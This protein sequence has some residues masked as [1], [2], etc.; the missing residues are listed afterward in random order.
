MRKG[1]KQTVSKFLSAGLAVAL[2][3]AATGCA[4][5]TT[6]STAIQT[7]SSAQSTVESSDK[8]TGD[9]SSVTYFMPDASAT[10]LQTL[11]WFNDYLREK[12]GIEIKPVTGDLQAVQAMMSSGEL[13]D[14]PGVGLDEIET[15]VKGNMLLNLDEYKDQ[16]SSL[17]TSDIYSS[18]VD[19]CRDAFGEGKA[20]Y[21]IQRQVGPRNTI[22]LDPQLR[23]DIYQKV[24]A[25]KIGTL[26]DYLTVLKSMQ[27]AYPTTEDG[28]KVYGLVLYGDW[29]ILTMKVAT[30]TS[31]FYGKD[32]EYLSLLHQVSADGNGEAISIL[33][34][35]SDYKRTLK[36]YYQANQMG[37]LDP[38]S[39][40]QTWDTVLD[41]YNNGRILFANWAWAGSGYN[42]SEHVNADNPTGYASV[43][44]DDFTIP[45]ESDSITGASDRLLNVS[46][47]CQNKDAVMRFLNWYLSYEGQEF[48]CNGPQGGLWDEDESGKR[49]ITDAGWNII[50]NGLE[51]PQGG[52]VSA[53]NL[54]LSDRPMW[55]EVVNPE[56]K[57][58]IDY[59]YWEDSLTHGRSKLQQ[60]WSSKHDGALDMI[61]AA[62]N[63]GGKQ[64]IKTTQAVHMISPLPDD[65]QTIQNQIGDQVKTISW[66]M[67]YAKDD[68]E[69]EQLWKE[70]QN[71]AKTL[72]IDQLTT[73]M[74]TEL[75][76]A[77]EKL[78][79][80][81]K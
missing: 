54:A 20:L 35:T 51:I 60:D 40:T 32:L 65:L 37:I 74:N 81:T 67:V 23:W 33:E 57:Q 22:N 31:E 17:Y 56:T 76:N 66:K 45:V 2:I 24:G 49:Y 26:E 41:K 34:D 72:G 19:Y 47:N 13:A 71:T 64:L 42:T 3:A 44:A 69:F 70:L 18:M 9:V 25:P 38:D 15:A 78:S 30:V 36:F 1:F 79:K 16:L 68:A 80:Y 46:A 7:E 58:T 21:S 6:S 73:W 12:I 55:K 50:D 52:I 29:D 63:A 61:E 39:L 14:I 11:T 28:Q 27:D 4:G 75:N 59:S 8:W 5:Q 48:C 10:A 43:W 62:Q 77:K 53:L